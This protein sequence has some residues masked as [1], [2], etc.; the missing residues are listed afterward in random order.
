[1]LALNSL[2]GLSAPRSWLAVSA[3][4]LATFSVVTTE[5]CL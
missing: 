1:M 4:A 2:P 3:A 5:F